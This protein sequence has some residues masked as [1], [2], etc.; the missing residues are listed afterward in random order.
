MQI[1]KWG[2]NV[3]YNHNRDQFFSLRRTGTAS[4]V[5]RSLLA[6]SLM[7][8]GLVASAGSALAA[9]PAPTA[10]PPHQAGRLPPKVKPQGDAAI[11]RT[12]IDAMG[13]IRG[14]GPRETTTTVNR[15]RWV[16]DGVMIE[17]GHTYKVTKFDY[18]LSLL[19]KAAREDIQRT[20]S[21]GV[22]SRVIEVVAGANA[23][24]ENAPG[25]Y[26]GLAQKQ[27]LERQLRFWRTPFGVAKALTLAP[28]G[29]V[30]VTD[31]GT[32]PVQLDLSVE[33]VPMQVTLDSDYRPAQITQTVGKK[34][35][36]VQYSD[37]HDFA[38]YGLMFPGHYVETVDGK[39]YLDIQLHSGDVATYVVFPPPPGLPVA[40]APIH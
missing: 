17:G 34:K 2:L 27:A 29:S 31:S 1:I 35:I 20:D 11:F 10:G 26:S 7:A 6:L 37:Y 14:F 25:V 4:T 38:E 8:A 36:V 5:S 19:Q 3:S 13:L 23:W 32:G 40:A 24:N 15:L 22:K 18:G 21:A 12:V 30:K 9:A 39:P 16:G 28:A 33:S